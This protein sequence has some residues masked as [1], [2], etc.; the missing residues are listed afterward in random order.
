MTSERRDTMTSDVQP[1]RPA[2]PLAD[3]GER[4]RSLVGSID[5]GFCLCEMVV[6]EA[7]LPIDYRFL[8]VNH[9]FGEMTGIKPDAVGRTARELVPGLE[10]RWVQMYARVGLGGE[11]IRFE[12][13]SAAMGRIFDVF[14]FPQGHGRFALLFRDITARRQ[15]ED[16]LRATAHQASFRAGLTDALRSLT[17]P[18]AI[19]DE[20]ARLLGRH[21][22]AS[23]SFFAEIEPDGDHALVGADFHD[24]VRSAVGRHRIE[25]FGA[26]LAAD[27][28]AG[29]TITV[30]DVGADPRLTEP[31]RAANRALGTGSQCMA[32][33]TREGRVVAILVVQD[34]QPRAWTSQDVSIVE[35]V[36]ERAWAAAER[37]RSEAALRESE[38]QLRANEARL[39]TALAVK[40]EFLGLVSHELR[41]PMTVILGMSHVLRRDGLS[42]DRVREMAVDIADSAEVLSGLVDSMLLLARLEQ[43]DAGGMREPILLDRLVGEMIAE[44]RRRDP[45]RPYEVRIETPG[46][47]V[48]V[49]GAWLERVVD[50]LVGNA[51]KYSD[52]GTP[53]SVVVDRDEAGLARV[54]VLDRGS[55]LPDSDLERLFEP[56]FRTASAE[57]RAPGAGLGLAVSR[58]IVELLGGRIWARA[59]DGGG[60]EFGF[61]LP[62]LD[63]EEG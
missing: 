57:Q 48:D 31:E 8:E 53:V 33:L 60:G 15:A 43:D 23:W 7:G 54:R 20:A 52:P 22:A 25:E 62:L 21:L 35:E 42:P 36:A 40:D 55:A 47:L 11:S 56:F 28:R 29:R 44:R 61:V 38:A 10:D 4:Y 30:D 27:I 3:P 51:A 37:A 24:G 63:P 1:E 5:E 32:C 14:A 58:R 18:D 12:E 6:D 9:L 41:T 39:R 34:R 16:A 13:G 45:S 59:R 26:A 46:S 49:Q 17:D 19:R 50:N 2:A